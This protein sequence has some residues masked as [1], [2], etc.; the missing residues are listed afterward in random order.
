MD[1]REIRQAVKMTRADFARY[2]GIPY[3]TVEEWESRRAKCAPYLIALI[4]YKLEKEG[5][6]HDE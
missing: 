2:F 4:R 5:L 6:L 1:I 3:R